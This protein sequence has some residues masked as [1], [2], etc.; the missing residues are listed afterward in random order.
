MTLPVT[1]SCSPSDNFSSQIGNEG[2]GLDDLVSK[3]VDDDQLNNA[4]LQEHAEL[5]G[6]NLKKGSMSTSN[7]LVFY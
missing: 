7:R 3:I 1:A 4:F 6:L 5:F 2:N